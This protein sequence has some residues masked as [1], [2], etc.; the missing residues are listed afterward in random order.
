MSEEASALSKIPPPPAAPG[1]YESICAALMQTERGRW[2]LEEYARRNRSADT[3]LLLAAIG[4]IEAVVCAERNRQA[5]QGFRSDLLDMAKAITRTRAEVAQIRSEPA[6]DPESAL[7]QSDAAPMRRAPPRDVFAAATRIRD[8]TWAMRGH[9]FD[10]STCDQLE[11]LAASILSASALG[12]P[13]DHRASKLSEVLQYLEHRIETLLESSADG[14]APGPE[15]APADDDDGFS[16]MSGFGPTS[17][18]AA[19]ASPLTVDI[20]R[21]EVLTLPERSDDPVSERPAPEP[22]AAA[23]SQPPDEV[24]PEQPVFA[25]NHE[26]AAQAEDQAEAAVNGLAHGAATATATLVVAA[27]L[28]QSA[29]DGAD[30]RPAVAIDAGAG[31]KPSSEPSAVMPSPDELSTRE[32]TTDGATA[33]SSDGNE[34]N[35]MMTLAEPEEALQ[36]TSQDPLQRAFQD[37]LQGPLLSVVELPDA[38]QLTLK[39]AA[40]RAASTASREVA[41]AL[42]P[43]ID[44]RAEV[45][46]LD[47]APAVAAARTAQIALLPQPPFADPLA[48]LKVMSDDELIALF[49]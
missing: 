37:A 47:A 16:P 23:P 34:T 27:P 33:P 29:E 36:S 20:R 44:M 42:L 28:G 43:E 32:A 3:Q 40:A 41:H 38:G 12:D 35:G 11:Q 14:D 39:A 15:A 45:R 30:A 13:S 26:C 22:A 24:A 8:V 5:Q 10:P 25:Q 19:Q 2:F 7:P 49:S 18:E 21:P 9:G 46:S 6:A 4:R 31:I 1:D 48:A 17:M